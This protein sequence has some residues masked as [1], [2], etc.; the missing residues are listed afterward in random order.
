MQQQIM[1]QGFMKED[2]HF[3]FKTYIREGVGKK[4]CPKLWVGGGQKS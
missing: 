3:P 2:T 4:L 1:N